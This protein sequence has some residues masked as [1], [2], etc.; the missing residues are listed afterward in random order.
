MRNTWRNNNEGVREGWEE[1][2][3]TSQ[4][5]WANKFLEGVF[6]IIVVYITWQGIGLNEDK[7]NW[8]YVNVYGI[9]DETG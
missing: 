8:C 4:W 6:S 2:W 9:V 7:L 1:R 3:L 5:N